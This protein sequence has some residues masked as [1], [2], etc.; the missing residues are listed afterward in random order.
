M[1]A[2]VW[3]CGAVWGQHTPVVKEGEGREIKAN[4]FN[5]IKTINL[6]KSN[7][8]IR[9]SSF[10][11]R[12]YTIRQVS[13]RFV[14]REDGKVPYIAQKQ[15]KKKANAVSQGSFKF[16]NPFVHCI[17][18]PSKAQS[19]GLGFLPGKPVSVWKRRNKAQLRSECQLTLTAQSST[20]HSTVKAGSMLAC[21]KKC[22]YRRKPALILALDGKTDSRYKPE[23]GNLVITF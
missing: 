1:W 23:K 21:T 16:C 10:H 6:P 17:F 19:K 11:I 7:C 22:Y 4:V 3:V 9:M 13:K 8:S 12:G 5:I 20:N 2:A 18:G 14:F 15:K